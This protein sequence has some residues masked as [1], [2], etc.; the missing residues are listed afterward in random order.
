[1]NSSEFMS[2]MIDPLTHDEMN[3]LYKANDIKYEKC[4]LYYDFIKSLNR[5]IVDTYMGD[6]CVLTKEQRLGHFNWCFQTVKDNFKKENIIFGNLDKLKDYFFNYHNELYYK[7]EDKSL[8]KIDALPELSFV[9]YKLKSRSD[10]DVLIDIYRL[11]EK[12]LIE[13]IKK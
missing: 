7:E 13:K 12:S 9:F 1:M 5:M 6:D 2:Y 10:V 3:L 8:Y 4:G 11:F